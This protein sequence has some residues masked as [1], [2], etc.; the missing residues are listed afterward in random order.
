MDPTVN[1]T[2]GSSACAD[3]RKDL[4]MKL[5]REKQQKCAG[6][7][8]GDSVSSCSSQLSAEQSFD[9]GWNQVGTTVHDTG[10]TGWSS[11]SFASM[12]REGGVMEDTNRTGQPDQ[13]FGPPAQPMEMD[14]AG[15]SGASTSSNLIQ[16]GS[17]D[18]VPGSKVLRELNKLF[19]LVLKQNE[20]ILALLRQPA[21]NEQ[22]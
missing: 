14:Y 2:G 21:G 19:D 22:E 9:M 17:T 5:W 15:Y 4:N 12:G 10:A 8:V 1:S 3:Y 11:A 20:E 6:P 16:S 18:L 13:S 7:S